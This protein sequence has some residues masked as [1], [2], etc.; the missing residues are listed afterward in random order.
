[1]RVG[2]VTHTNDGDVVEHSAG[3]VVGVDGYLAAGE[4]EQEF[5][6]AAGC[7]FESR[8]RSTRELGGIGGKTVSS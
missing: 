4:I 5:L 3:V 6:F 1:M 7:F 2:V 8:P